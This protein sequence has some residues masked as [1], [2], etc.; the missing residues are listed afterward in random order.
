MGEGAWS[1]PLVGTPIV[2]WGR[3][4][5][6]RLRGPHWQSNEGPPLAVFSDVIGPAM[7]MHIA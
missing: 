2:P 5:G 4:L 7:T 6:G 3:R 1:G